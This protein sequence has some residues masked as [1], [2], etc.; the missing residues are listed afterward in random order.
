[1]QT[2]KPANRSEMLD[3]IR[4]SAMQGQGNV[5]LT[6]VLAVLLVGSWVRMRLSRGRFSKAFSRSS[7]R[8]GLRRTLT[9]AGS[10]QRATRAFRKVA[11]LCLL[12]VAVKVFLTVYGHD[13]SHLHLH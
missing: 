11:A 12:V 7:T 3:P 10:A 13:A 4:R 5:L 9:R 2:G 1:M 8:R 6:A